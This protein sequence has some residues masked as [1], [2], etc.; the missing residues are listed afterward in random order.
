MLTGPIRY[1]WKGKLVPLGLAAVV[2]A[3]FLAFLVSGL[4]SGAPF[5]ILVAV[6]F[7][8][9]VVLSPLRKFFRAPFRPVFTIAEGGI[10]M[11]GGFTI[12]WEDIHEAVFFNHEGADSFG[13]RLRGKLTTM[14]DRQLAALTKDNLDY[15]VYRMPLVT[16]TRVLAVAQDDLIEVF[17]RRGVRVRVNQKLIEAGDESQV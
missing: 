1:N 10:R 4:R 12:P 9:A 5:S 13:I 8:V 15:S 7:L 3:V 6:V 16:L 2:L 17:Q 11:P 14:T